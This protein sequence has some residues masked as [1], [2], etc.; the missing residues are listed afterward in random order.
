MDKL[1]NKQ[2]ILERLTPPPE[3]WSLMHG[4]YQLRGSVGT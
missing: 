2:R 1:M 3:K 4:L